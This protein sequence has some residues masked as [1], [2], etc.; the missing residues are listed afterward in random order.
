[1][2]DIQV[3]A[4]HMLLSKQ[5]DK[6][7]SN[8]PLLSEALSTYLKLKGIG[9]DKTFVR[10]ANRNVKYVI[11]LLGDLPNLMEE[12]NLLEGSMQKLIKT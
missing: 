10:E 7:K 3:P 2:T 9:K 11:K 5:L 1:M 4:Q 12:S 8:A 6:S